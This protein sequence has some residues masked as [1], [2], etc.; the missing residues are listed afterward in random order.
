MEAMS[1]LSFSSVISKTVMKLSKN[2]RWS[3]P[4]KVDNMVYC[5]SSGTNAIK[6]GNLSSV[7]T[8]RSSEHST[9]LGSLVLTPNG[10]SNDEI[11]V[12][13]LVPY[14]QYRHDDGIGITKFLRG[15]AFLITGA[16]GFLGKVLIEKILRTAPDVNKIFILI[17]AKNKEVAIQRLKN[18]ILNADIFNC[19]KQVHGKTY[20]TFM[21]SKLVP[22]VGNVCESNLGID[23]DTANMMGKE[24]D[25]IVNSAANTTFDERYDIALDI[26]TG[27]PGRLM[28]FA[29]QCHNLKLFLQVSTGKSLTYVNGQRQGRIMENPFCIGDSIARENLLSGVNH[30]SFHSLNVEDEIKL[31]LESKQAL[32]DNSV[33][34]KM[35]EIGLQ[36]ANKFGWQDTYVFT[37]AMGEMMIDSMRGDI[38]VVI[39]RPSVIES[40]YK[41]PFPG[42]MEGSRMMDPII[43]YYGKGQLTGFLV[44]PNGVLDV[45]AD[46]VVNATLAAMAKHGAEGKPGSSS[47]YQVASSAV[48][49]LVFKDLARMLFD[50]FNR[51]PYTDSKGRP[52]H[53]PKMSLLRSMEDLSSHLWR[54]AINRSGLTDLANPNGKLSRKLENICRKSVE[55]AKYLANIYQPYT[56]Y[57]G[58]FD[59]SNTQR[60]M[61]CMSKEERWQFG[62]DVESIDWKDYISNVH[63]PGLRKH[64]MKGR[65]SCS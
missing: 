39:I 13:D 25:I 29:K 10:S 62:F 33:A 32:E 21:L 46:M 53:V 41:E 61:E 22:V 28:N 57:G 43:L 23:E 11:K 14:G 15:K 16:T 9:A 4:M 54:D 24:V 34:Q 65:G 1:T 36:R 64:V 30:N 51:S 48:N 31:V 55:Q 50:H 8:E 49:P 35:K 19:L 7:I 40:T 12:K 47:V 27:G 17:K 45:P 2:C 3:P 58:R 26:N 6:S 60:L 20:Q 38:P 44:D 56:F 18:E 5:Q 59:N 37:K 42:W 63:I 52:I